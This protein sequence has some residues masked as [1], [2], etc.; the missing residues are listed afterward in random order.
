MTGRAIVL[1]DNV[2]T[3]LIIPARHLAATSREELGRHCFEDLDPEFAAHHRPGDIVVAGRNFGCGSSREHAPLALLGAGVAAVVAASYAR[4]FFRNAINV[5]LPILICSAAA[6][7]V[8]PGDE[9]ELDLAAGTVRDQTSGASWRAE[10]L[11]P[12]VLDIIAA[13]GLVEYT[14]RRLLAGHD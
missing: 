3:D 9:L 8:R 13:G 2:D 14:R 12:F 10:P 6:A 5:G 1:G 11:P 4:I 7:A